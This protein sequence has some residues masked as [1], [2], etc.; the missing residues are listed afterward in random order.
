MAHEATQ[1][2]TK[3]KRKDIVLLEG[4]EL[5]KKSAA[6]RNVCSLYIVALDISYASYL[7]FS[8][9]IKKIK[10]SSVRP[11]LYTLSKAVLPWFC[12]NKFGN[13]HFFN[14][15][16]YHQNPEPISLCFGRVKRNFNLGTSI[17]LCHA[18]STP[19][20]FTHTYVQRCKDEQRRCLNFSYIF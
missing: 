13:W 12:N 18:G 14:H 15:R 8:C 16:S 10:I 20:W 19:Q 2:V 11:I 9:I 5:S 4:N 6:F 3:L 7:D 1:V 17:R